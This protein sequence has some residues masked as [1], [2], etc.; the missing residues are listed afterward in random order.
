MFSPVAK[1][2]TVRVLI[3]LATTFKWDLH[4]IDI[5]NAFLHGHLEEE[6]YMK[7]P[8][9]YSKTK[10]GEVCRLRKSLYGL[11]QASRAWNIQLKG[12]L[13]NLGYNQAYN[14]YSLFCKREGNN[15]TMLL[16]YVDDLLIT[17]N[18]KEEI[19]RVKVLLNKQFTIK[20]LG[21]ARYFLGIEIARSEKGTILHQRKFISDILE[22][23]GMTNC[24]PAPFPLS[25]G[26]QLSIDTG[27]LLE[28]PEPYRR[29]IGKLLYLNLTRPDLSYSIH[30]LSQFMQTPRKPHFEA[31]LYIVRYLKGTI[32]WGLY[33]SNNAQFSLTSYCDA[34][35]E[36]C[37]YNAR[38][39]TRYC[40]FLGELYCLLEDK[41]TKNGFKIVS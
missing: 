30:Q 34:D 31:A 27:E 35:W 20:D 6:I 15:F 11:K 17:G 22:T 28:D 21:E 41:E 13:K 29:L 12:F 36:T 5:N 3:A 1:F 4:H 8:K 9:G 10:Q 39:L 23:T 26:L 24:K 16:A 14:E 7:P 25:K 2:T 19:A 38:S 32:N 40:V 37:P 18:N 33:Y